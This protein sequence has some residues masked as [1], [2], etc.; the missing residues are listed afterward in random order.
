MSGLTYWPLLRGRQF[1]LLALQLLTQENLLTD[2]IVPIIEPIRDAA[3]LP[4]LLKLR[5]RAGLPTVV[6]Q[7][8]SVGTYGLDNQKRYPLTAALANPQVLQGWWW[9]PELAVPPNQMLLLDD[10]QLLP[11]AD[12]IRQARYL[13]VP[14]DPR[15]LHA[16]QHPRRIF[17]HDPWPRVW[18]TQ[19]FGQYA[20]TPLLAE[21]HWAAAHGFVGIS[22]YSLS[23]APYF[24]KGW[25]Q[26]TIALHIAYFRDG[27]VWLHH[28]LP[29]AASGPQAVQFQRLQAELR[30]WLASHRHSILWDAPLR[31]LLHYG[32][33]DHYPG[34]GVIKKLS[35]A[36]QI[37]SVQHTLS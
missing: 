34:L 3:V 26:G 27:G 36:H 29:P 30:R 21:Q 8:P 11:P 15:I 20:D 31:E 25:A 14:S 4:R 10:P 13:V 32:D 12:I 22:D 2:R 17:L 24:D 33:I 37:L 16:V 28:F 19:E 35:V 23:G 9:R 1:D 7:N 6:I 5:N 18:R